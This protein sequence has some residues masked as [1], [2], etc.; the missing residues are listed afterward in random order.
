MLLR[1]DSGRVACYRAAGADRRW[2][3]LGW[4]LVAAGIVAAIA[5]VGC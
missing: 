3:V 2:R 5:R 1:D 4:A